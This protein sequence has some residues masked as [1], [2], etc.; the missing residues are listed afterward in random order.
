[1]AQKRGGIM[2]EKEVEAYN[3]GYAQGR[4][5]GRVDARVM[6]ENADGCR[7]CAFIDVYEWEMPCAK[8]SR[9]CK[10]YWR[11]KEVE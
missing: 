2:T 9:N 4:V 1:M 3:R 6:K 11:A 8:C 5:Q 10:D 7:G